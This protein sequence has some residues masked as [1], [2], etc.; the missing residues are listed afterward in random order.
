MQFPEVPSSH[1]INNGYNVITTLAL[2]PYFPYLQ[3]HNF[4][5]NLLEFTTS[6]MHVHLCQL[7]V[8]RDKVV[9]SCNIC[10]HILG[11]VEE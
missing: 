1:L 6:S 3:F 2:S 4:I 7:I 9:A 11:I 8:A 10:T 5:H